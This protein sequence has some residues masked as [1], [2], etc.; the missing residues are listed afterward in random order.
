MVLSVTLT[1]YQIQDESL[2]T[3]IELMALELGQAIQLPIC[4]GP[5][6]R[7]AMR[8]KKTSPVIP[9]E[10]VFHD[11]SYL[12]PSEVED[13]QKIEFGSVSSHMLQD[14]DQETQNDPSGYEGFANVIHVQP[15]EGEVSH[16]L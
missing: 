3:R 5:T 11:D 7:V 9:Q 12:K 13:N 16:H 6:L 10:P 4:I 15:C 14:E 2:V 1:S 8:K